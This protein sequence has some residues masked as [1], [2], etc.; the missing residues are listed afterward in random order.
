V[1]QISFRLSL[2]LLASLFAV[3]FL[4]IVVPPL[5]ASGD[6]WDGIRRGFVNPY[7]TGYA[8]D[9]ILCWF[10]LCAWV[11]HERLTIGVRHGWVALVLGVV[12]GVAVGFAA[13]LLLRQRARRPSSDPDS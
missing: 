2:W 9:A 13:Y 11:V 7:A 8:L 3:A 5:L 1:E 12:P 4:L 6:V 10:V